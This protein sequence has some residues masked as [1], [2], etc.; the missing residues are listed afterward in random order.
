MDSGDTLETKAMREVR[1]GHM[2][3]KLEVI[4]E[5]IILASVTADQGQVLEQVPIETELG[6][7]SVE[8]MIISQETAQQHKQREVEQ[9]KQMFNMDKEQTLLQM[10]LIDTGQVRQSVNITEGRKNLKL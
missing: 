4:T 6:V 1:A 2:I 9:I 7:S 10:L 5:E 3:G 8:T